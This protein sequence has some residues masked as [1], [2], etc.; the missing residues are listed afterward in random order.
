M[1]ET[2]ISNFIFSNVIFELVYKKL[3]VVESLRPMRTLDS[4]RYA[5]ASTLSDVNTHTRVCVPRR[6]D[7]QSIS[8]I[9]THTLI[10]KRHSISRHVHKKF[11]RHS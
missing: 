8:F 5:C 10:E 3:I 2:I 6:I 1:S 9:Y 4:A 11:I 7:L